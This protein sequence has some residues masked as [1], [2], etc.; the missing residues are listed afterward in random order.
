[1]YLPGNGAAAAIGASGSG[2][3]GAGGFSRGQ[4]TASRMPI[5]NRMAAT[6]ER[7]T[8]GRAID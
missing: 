4:K 3:R 1:M 2:A 6:W 8:E 7:F 5:N